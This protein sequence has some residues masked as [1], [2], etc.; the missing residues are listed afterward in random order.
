MLKKTFKDLLDNGKSALIS[1]YPGNTDPSQD[2]VKLGNLDKLTN[3]TI[4]QQ[5][6]NNINPQGYQP[7]QIKF[8]LDHTKPILDFMEDKVR[9]K[10]TKQ[11]LNLLLRGFKPQVP[12]LCP[13]SWE[14]I[15]LQQT[16]I[17]IPKH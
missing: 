10:L 5:Y 16:W 15:L 14:L 17:A 11:K 1:P 7:N 3:R 6:C 9:D 12:V 4:M 2:P 13:G 8:L